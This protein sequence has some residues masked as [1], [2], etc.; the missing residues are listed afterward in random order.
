MKIEKDW[1]EYSTTELYEMLTYFKKMN[2]ESKEKL[3]TEVIEGSNGRSG[4]MLG[5]YIWCAL[6]EDTWAMKG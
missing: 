6:E 1:D 3:V 4:G 5:Y 2:N